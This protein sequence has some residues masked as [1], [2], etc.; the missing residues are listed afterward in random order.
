MPKLP[1]VAIIGKPNTGKSTLFNRL[2]GRR[3]AIVSDTPG[4]TRD[5]VAARIETENT[6][7][8]LVDTGGMGGGTDDVDFEDDVHRQSMLA[9]QNADLI[10]FT[11]DAQEAITSRDIEIAA[12]L[13]KQRKAHVPVI[14]V[15]TKCDNAE[16]AQNALPELYQLNAGEDVV[17]VSAPHRMGID[18]L[19][20]AIER[21]LKELHFEKQTLEEGAIPKIAIIG[22]PN[23]GKSSL[24][25]AF[26][27]ETQRKTSPLLVSEIAGTTR[28]ATD[29]VIRYHEKDY[30]FMDTAGIKRKSQ[31][32]SDIEVNAF[33]RG[34]RALEACDIAVLVADVH[35][36]LSRQDKR[37][38]RMAVTEGKGLIVLLNKADLL[39]AEER[40]QKVTDIRMLLSFCK[41]APVLPVSA[42]TRDGLLKLFEL[43]ETAERNRTRRIPTKTLIRWFEDTVYGQ[44]MHALCRSKHMTQAQDLPPT[45]I[46]FV[47]DPRK[48]A[49]SHLKFLENRMR[50]TFAFEG[51]PIRWVT[52]GPNDD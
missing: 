37:I 35:E 11:V 43:I 51:T 19:T 38:A 49:V 41:F 48:I 47:K 46:L 31:G 17:A 33:F 4:T 39:T 23:V 25:N 20:E 52:K 16:L 7:F 15:A 5:H 13:R 1:V 32:N 44:P 3:K 40:K 9:L 34:V 18:E 8:L 6:D 30:L 12:I 29:T 36:P 28:D 22:K 14:V 10:L 45:F 24:I 50:E 21:H 2:I 27:S 42:K 26:M